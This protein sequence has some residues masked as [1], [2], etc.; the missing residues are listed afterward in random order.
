MREFSN[1]ISLCFMII[2]LNKSWLLYFLS[3]FFQGINASIPASI[4]H[5]SQK[6][7]QFIV[8]VMCVVRLHQNENLFFFSFPSISSMLFSFWCLYFAFS[9]WCLFYFAFSCRALCQSKTA[10][11]GVRVL[12]QHMCA[13]VPERA[14]YRSL[15][16]EVWHVEKEHNM[17]KFISLK[18]SNTC[19][20]SLWHHVMIEWLLTWCPAPYCIVKMQYDKTKK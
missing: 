7:T 8:Y 17:L 10:L 14:E 13:S 9:F 2:Y 18:W 19:N 1:L 15:V 20:R 11:D 5:V 4:R 12:L 3:Y 16:G 6:T